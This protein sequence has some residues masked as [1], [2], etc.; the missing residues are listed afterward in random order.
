MKG[1]V[2]LVGPDPGRKQ[3]EIDQGRD[4]KAKETNGTHLPMGKKA[5]PRR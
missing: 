5:T 4:Q 2:V 3:G 1:S